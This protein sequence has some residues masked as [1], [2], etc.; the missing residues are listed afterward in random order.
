MRWGRTLNELL[1]H[2]VLLCRPSCMAA[3]SEVCLRLQARHGI[4]G[5]LIGNNQSRNAIL[6]QHCISTAGV[7]DQ[8]AGCSHGSGLFD[9]PGK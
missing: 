5:F 8:V 3:G 1:Q 2:A 4:I 6:V 9:H 7:M